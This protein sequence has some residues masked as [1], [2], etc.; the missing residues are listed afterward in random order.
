MTSIARLILWEH[1]STER[2]AVPC[3]L[4]I[5]NF[6]ID[7]VSSMVRIRDDKVCH[8]DVPASGA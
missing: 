6:G 7:P 3:T 1:K 2:T 8:L 5:R 4:R